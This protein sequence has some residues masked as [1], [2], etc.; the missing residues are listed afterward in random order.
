MKFQ[1]D[2]IVCDEE[3]NLIVWTVREVNVARH[4]KSYFQ[5][6]Y[7]TFGPKLMFIGWL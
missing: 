5:S 6:I 3:G 7:R 4:I 2:A 1:K